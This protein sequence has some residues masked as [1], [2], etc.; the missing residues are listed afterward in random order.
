MKTRLMCL[1]LVAV[2]TQ[3]AASGCCFHP[4]ERWHANHPYGTYHHHPLLHP[5]QTRRAIFAQGFPGAGAET[6]GPVVMNPPCHGC[7]AAPGLPVSYGSAPSDLVPTTITP[8]FGTPTPLTPGPQV[9]P[10]Y[11]LPKPMASPKN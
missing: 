6:A 4:I 8:T 5:I 10:S 2:V 1:G 3:L 9:V 7:G 11:E